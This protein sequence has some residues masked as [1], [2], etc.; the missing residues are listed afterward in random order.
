MLWRYPEEDLEKNGKDNQFYIILV[1]ILI[2][3]VFL[4]WITGTNIIPFSPV[5]QKLD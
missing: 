2:I 1:F 4:I 3:F 5:E